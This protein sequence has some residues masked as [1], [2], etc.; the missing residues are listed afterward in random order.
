MK[1]IIDSIFKSLDAQNYFGALFMALTIPDICASVENP[2]NKKRG[3]RYRKWFEENLKAK[4]Y[5]ESM[6]ELIE[7]TRPELAL[8]L[9]ESEKL[10]LRVEPVGELAFTDDM[11]WKL[12]CSVLH[13]GSTHAGPFSFI[14]THGNSHRNIIDGVLQLS[15]VRLCNDICIAFELWCEKNKDNED[16]KKRLLEGMRIHN[17][18]NKHMYFG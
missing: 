2:G 5:P 3:V 13:E 7:N 14:L 9:D 16:I 6:L 10:R 18:I 17:Q 8:Q 15:T 12:R 1:A 4:Y 11:C